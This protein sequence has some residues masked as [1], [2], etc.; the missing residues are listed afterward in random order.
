MCGSRLVAVVF[1]RHHVV[2]VFA[3]R[4]PVIFV[5]RCVASLHC[6]LRIALRGGCLLCSVAWCCTGIVFAQHCAGVVFVWYC[7]GVAWGGCRLRAALCGSCLY[8]A[9]HH[10]AGVFVWHCVAQ[11]S[12]SRGVAWVSSLRGVAQCCLHAV[13]CGCV[14]AWHCVAASSRRPGVVVARPVFTC[15]RTAVVFA[16]PL[17]TGHCHLHCHGHCRCLVAEGQR[18]IPSRAPA[19]GGGC[20]G[21]GRK[22]GDGHAL[23]SARPCL[24][25]NR[26]HKRGRRL[27][28]GGA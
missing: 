19:N 8:V 5:R 20:A 10:V 13:S 15:R 22:R 26:G 1:V 2:V 25:T 18:Y 9:S 12:S 11:A 3:R 6:G 24:H 17:L 16:S 14:F 4:A 23:A 28:R 27:C 7:I 21:A